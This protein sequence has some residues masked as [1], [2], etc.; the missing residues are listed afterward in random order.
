MVLVVRNT[1]LYNRRSDCHH[2]K[3]RIDFSLRNGGA[4]RH[5]VSPGVMHSESQHHLGCSLAKDIYLGSSHPV[6]VN[7][8]EMKG[9]E[10]PAK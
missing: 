10:E 3:L 1:Q 4:T 9:K 8:R 5:Y 7:F 6:R 2:P